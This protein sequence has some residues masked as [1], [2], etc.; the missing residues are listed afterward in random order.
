[1]NNNVSSFNANAI[2]IPINKKAAKTFISKKLPVRSQLLS[3]TTLQS[4]SILC[5]T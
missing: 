3:K 4:D 5:K 2:A 1:M